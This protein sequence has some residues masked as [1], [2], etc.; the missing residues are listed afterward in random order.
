MIFREN[1][2]ENSSHL[3]LLL[4][5]QLYDGAVDYLVNN[6]IHL[7][8]SNTIYRVNLFLRIVSKL[9]RDRELMLLKKTCKVEQYI[10]CV[11]IFT[12]S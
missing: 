8:F 2:V 4:A 10:Q 5:E 12:K 6:A 3:M 11:W 1:L 7:L 9:L